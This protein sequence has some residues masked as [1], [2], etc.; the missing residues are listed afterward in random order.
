MLQVSCQ[1]T[2]K[3]PNFSNP[4]NFV[5]YE[6]RERFSQFVEHCML[7]AQQ[8]KSNLTANLLGIPKTIKICDDKMFQAQCTL[9][10]VASM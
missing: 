1:L 10:I 7:Q 9:A 5:T 8:Q 4:T 2:I 3:K 6:L